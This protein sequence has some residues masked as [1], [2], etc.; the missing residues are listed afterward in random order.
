MRLGGSVLVEASAGDSSDEVGDL[1][2]TIAVS[3]HAG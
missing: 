3:E 1:N 2:R